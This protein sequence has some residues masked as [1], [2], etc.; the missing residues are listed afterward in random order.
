MIQELHN[1]LI[2]VEKSQ[3]QQRNSQVEINEFAG[4]VLGAIEASGRTKQIGR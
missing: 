3:E 2:A 1:R 4:K